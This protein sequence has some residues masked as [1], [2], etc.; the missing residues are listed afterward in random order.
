MK[1]EKLN[2]RDFLKS[3]A[4]GIIIGGIAVTGLNID[5][6]FA[7]FD[8]IESTGADKVLNLADYPDLANTGGYKQISGKLIVFRTGASSFRALNPTCTHK[9]CDT[10]F[11][12]KE[13]ECECHGSK[14]DKTGKVLN[15]PATKNLRSYKTTFDSSANT[16]TIKM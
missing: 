9:K 1:Q 5:K 10:H 6:V 14:F 2:R 8:E 7:G 12:G 15:G 16:L 3:T 4:K 11:N 13:F